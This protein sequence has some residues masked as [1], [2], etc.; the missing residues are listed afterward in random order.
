MSTVNVWGHIMGTVNTVTIVIECGWMVLCPTPVTDITGPDITGPGITGADPHDEGGPVTYSLTELA[1]RQRSERADHP[2]LPVRKKL[3][4]RH[5]KSGRDTVYGAEH[6]ERL[7]LI[8]ELRDPR[9]SVPL[10]DPARELVATDTIRRAPWPSGSGWTPLP[11]HRGRTNKE[12]KDGQPRRAL[13]DR[14]TAH[15]VATPGVIGELQAGGYVQPRSD[16]SLLDGAESPTLLDQALQL[17][18]CGFFIDVDISAKV[19]DLLRR[20]LARAVDDTVTLLVER[21]IRIAGGA[22]AD[23]LATAVGALRPI[24]REMSSVILAQEVERALSDLVDSGPKRLRRAR[25]R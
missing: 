5:G 12:N 9:L 10:H 19:R 1:V 4:P 15:G 14:G 2:L 25:R 21:R 23:E 6:L 17:R 8:G 24:S 18:R 16:G 7:T 11:R 22:S 3:L 13:L 20:R